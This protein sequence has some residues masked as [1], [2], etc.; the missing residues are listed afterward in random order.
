MSDGR[1]GRALSSSV[2]GPSPAC[3]LPKGAW[4][5]G[6]SQAGEVSSTCEGKMVGRMS[7]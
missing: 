2:P 5:G 6:Q 4:E 3:S 1:P 7:H